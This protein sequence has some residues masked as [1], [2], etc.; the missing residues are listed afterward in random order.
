MTTVRGS[1]HFL[2]F[3]PVDSVALVHRII[4]SQL[5]CGPSGVKA[6]PRE[7]QLHDMQRSL[8]SSLWNQN[9]IEATDA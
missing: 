5:C 9:D 6:A 1:D 7:R 8:V 2:C 4:I 3:C